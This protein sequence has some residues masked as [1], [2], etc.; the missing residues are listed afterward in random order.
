MEIGVLGIGRTLDCLNRAGARSRI[1]P[2]S[3]FVVYQYCICPPRTPYL[4]PTDG[5]ADRLIM[6]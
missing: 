4:D 6:C 5:P 1:N 2:V 3:V